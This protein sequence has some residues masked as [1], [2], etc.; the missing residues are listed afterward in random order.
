MCDKERVLILLLRNLWHVRAAALVGR[1]PESIGAAVLRVPFVDVLTTMLDPD[2]PLTVHEQS[3]FGN[4]SADEE[5]FRC[6][7]H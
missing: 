6:Y 5:V 1:R 2:L 4:P 3:E 7:R